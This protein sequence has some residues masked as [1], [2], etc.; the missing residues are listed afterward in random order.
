[1]RWVQHWIIARVSLKSRRSLPYQLGSVLPD[2]FAI[3]PIHRTTESLDKFLDRA[4][5]LRA[6]PPGLRRDWY[7][8]TLAHYACD[9]CT[10]SHNEEYYR[11]YRHRV[12]EVLAQ[13]LIRAEYKKDPRRY[14]L[15]A[16]LPVPAALTDPATAPEAFRRELKDFLL[17]QIDRL[18]GEIRDLHTEQWY[19]D[20]RVAELDIRY[21][22]LILYALLCI[23]GE[24]DVLKG[25]DDGNG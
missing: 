13:D 21:A 6:L 1:M 8:G 17:T 16:G 7:L 23:F 24:P 3:H 2:W 19:R 10:Q 5:K 15:K 11:F 12:Y 22:C 25:D 20:P 18:H 4:V 9:Y 14:D